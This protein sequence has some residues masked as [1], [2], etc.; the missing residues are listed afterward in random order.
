MST[1]VAFEKHKNIFISTINALTDYSPVLKQISVLEIGPKRQKIVDYRDKYLIANPA[2]LSLACK[3]VYQFT[4]CYPNQDP[5]NF[6]RRLMTEI[7][8]LKDAPIWQGN[9][10]VS[11]GDKRSISSLNKPFSMAIDAIAKEL[12]ITLDPQETLI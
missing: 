4:L 5:L 11:R 1:R 9:V 8:W 6:I 12:N 10:V 3:A 2:G 7:D